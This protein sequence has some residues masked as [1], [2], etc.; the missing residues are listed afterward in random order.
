MDNYE[1]H[2]SYRPEGKFGLFL[3]NREVLDGPKITKGANVLMWVI[4]KSFLED[5]SGQVSE[6]ALLEVQKKYNL[7]ASGS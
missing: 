7:R 6:R 5:K 2:E 3:I 1:W 4:E